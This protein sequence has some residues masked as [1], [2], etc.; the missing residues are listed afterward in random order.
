[1]AYNDNAYH[2]MGY[3][4]QAE[5]E[6]FDRLFRSG[7]RD[8]PEARSDGVL[9]EQSAEDLAREQYARKIGGPL[10]QMGVMQDQGFSTAPSDPEKGYYGPDAL[11]AE[12]QAQKDAGILQAKQDREDD[13]L[14]GKRQHEFAIQEQATA[15]A[16]SSTR[17]GAKALGIEVPAGLGGEGLKYFLGQK[18]IERKE[19]RAAEAPPTAY[20]QATMDANQKMEAK[21]KLA[22]GMEA[23][24]EAHKAA[25]VGLPKGVPVG[26]DQDSFEQAV[27]EFN[28][29]NGEAQI[30]GN[31]DPASQMIIFSNLG[32]PGQEPTNAS[33]AAAA[34][35]L[36]PLPGGPM[37]FD[38]EALQQA[39][40]S[41][42]LAPPMEDDGNYDPYAVTPESTSGWLMRRM[43]GG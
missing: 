40:Q 26:K 29:S 43:T 22:A 18:D 23:G 37:P 36:P 13:L 12:G 10:A 39:A 21:A 6:E 17:E 20:Q 38:Q 1:M 33:Q 28:N 30:V 9:Y 42:D 8:M 31:Y 24:N 34:D 14:E 11:I 27:Q 5:E 15:K 2:D 4:P 7:S 35:A 41:G 25:M 3:N 19:A 16:D 32:G